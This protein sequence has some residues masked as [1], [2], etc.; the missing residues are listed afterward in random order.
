MILKV[1]FGFL[2]ISAGM[3]IGLATRDVLELRR[4]RKEYKVD[5]VY[6]GEGTE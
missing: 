3:A 5:S 1:L 2:L 6:R 4:F